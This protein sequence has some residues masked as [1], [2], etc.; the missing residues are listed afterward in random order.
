MAERRSGDRRSAGGRDRARE[1]AEGHRPPTGMAGPAARPLILNFDSRTSNKSRLSIANL[2]HTWAV[3]SPCR[4]GYLVQSDQRYETNGP[5]S[6]PAVPSRSP[7]HC[8]LLPYDL[9]EGLQSC[10]K[11]EIFFERLSLTCNKARSRH[12]CVLFISS[13]SMRNRLRGVTAPV[14]TFGR[15]FRGVFRLMGKRP[16]RRWATSGS[17]DNQPGLAGRSQRRMRATRS[18]AA[19]YIWSKAN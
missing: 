6:D 13:A 8:I 11:T 16:P 7:V 5:H 17:F 1:P 12:A 14:G 3:S 10:S 15:G 4:N 9:V 18:H 19:T 2:R